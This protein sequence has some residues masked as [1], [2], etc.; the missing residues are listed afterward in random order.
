[1][2]LYILSKIASANEQEIMR[3]AFVEW[4][5]LFTNADIIQMINE[6][7]EVTNLNSFFAVCCRC[8]Y[9]Y[10]DTF[11]ASFPSCGCKEITVC[12]WTHAVRIS[13]IDCF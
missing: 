12:R 6:Q 2:S 13:K 3:G 4:D 8:S 10:S 7:L 11:P 9:N 5:E 1:M